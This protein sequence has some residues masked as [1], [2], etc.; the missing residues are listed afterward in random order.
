MKKRI[1][2]ST[3]IGAVLVSAVSITLIIL[4]FQGDLDDPLTTANF[5]L[6]LQQTT[7][8]P[9]SSFG[10]TDTT[11][12][13]IGN[14]LNTTESQKTQTTVPPTTAP[15]P[16]GRQFC[17]ISSP[18]ADTWSGLAS[19]DTFT[20]MCTT[21]VQGTIDYITGQSRVFDE[22]ENEWR[23]FYLLASGRKVQTD[24]V[25]LLDP[26]ANYGDNN[27]QV[28]SSGTDNGN[29]IIRLK[30]AWNAPYSFEFSG[31]NYYEKN[32]K[33]YHV[34]AFTADKIQFTFYHTTAAEG[35]VN[36]GADSVVA[37][38]YWTVNQQNKTASL[39]MPLRVVGQYYGY[40]MQRDADGTLVLTIKKKPNGIAGAHVMLDPGHGGRDPG[41]LGFSGAVPEAAVNFAL[42]VATKQALERR[43]AIVYFTRTDDV[44]LSLEER[45]Q[46]ARQTN[47][48]VFVSIH[49]NAAENKSRYGTSTY[50]FRPLSQ[51]LAQSVYQ[52]LLA[53]YQNVLY[54]GDAERRARVGENANFHPFSVTR[55]EECPSI[56]I[57]TGYVTNDRE[58]TLLL[59]ADNRAKLGEA[60]AAGI[61]AYLSVK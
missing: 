23:D 20:P 21:L 14:Y 28:V 53:V 18:F 7:E 34:T 4:H 38:A 1:L 51:P 16:T 55:L 36:I 60:I 37:N 43:G 31:Q 44:Y 26:S 48:D 32:G 56:L 30:C 15:L 3:L 39:T 11:D 40:T 52:Q 54:A 50:Y 59:S 45:K 2:L 27:V 25:Q 46:I 10:Q 33:H 13:S 42:A 58:C 24:A 47:P 49:C 17:V 57:E 41:A 19:D 35:A 29:L 6:L 5:D 8:E 61:E 12:H 9:S 22:E